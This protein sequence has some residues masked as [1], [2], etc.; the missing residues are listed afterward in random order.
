MVVIQFL[1]KL[2]LLIANNMILTMFCPLKWLGNFE[3]ILWEQPLLNILHTTS[4]RETAKSLQP[5][6]VSNSDIEK[7]RTDGFLPTKD[8]RT[9]TV[10]SEIIFRM[11]NMKAAHMYLGL[12]GC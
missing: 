4:S 7:L 10:R 6:Y 12:G 2:I 11:L 1:I 8:G 3:N 9:V 5:L